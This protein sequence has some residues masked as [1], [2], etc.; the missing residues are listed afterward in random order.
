MG[1]NMAESNI[2]LKEIKICSMISFAGKINLLYPCH[3]FLW[4]VK[5]P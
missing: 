5:E 2:F 3:K 4:H 1:S